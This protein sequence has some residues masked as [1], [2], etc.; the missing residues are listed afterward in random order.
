MNFLDE[1]RITQDILREVERAA[2]KHPGTADMPDGTRNGGMWLEQRARAQSSCDRAAREQRLTF[3]HVLEEEFY[4][5]LC[6]E[7]KMKLREEIV[8]VC[9]VG[10]RWLAKLDREAGR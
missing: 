9:A 7:D 6:E 2:R 3:A 8:Q 4:E 1:R 5:V 10:V